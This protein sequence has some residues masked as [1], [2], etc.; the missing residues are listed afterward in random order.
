MPDNPH[1]ITALCSETSASSLPSR[2]LYISGLQWLWTVWAAWATWAA[3][4]AW[5][6]WA[7][8]L[9]APVVLGPEALGCVALS[10][11]GCVGCVGCMALDCVALGCVA[12][13][14]ISPDRLLI[15][16]Q[17]TISLQIQLTVFWRRFFGVLSWIKWMDCQTMAV[18][19]VVWVSFVK[20]LTLR[21]EFQS[22][23]TLKIY[24]HNLHLMICKLHPDTS[25][26]N[27]TP[28]S[29]VLISSICLWQDLTIFLWLVWNSICRPG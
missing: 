2:E 4:A 11:A 29:F 28:L 7:A 15:P 26:W 6:V 21:M 22:L 17:N 19:E 18:K 27:C 20:K 25:H 8:W 3:W 1:H 14:C 13:G 12:L 23:S 5:V 9:W 24:E 10:C 16:E